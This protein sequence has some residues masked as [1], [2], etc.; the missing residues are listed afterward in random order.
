MRGAIAAYLGFAAYGLFW[1]TWGAALPALRDT[2]GVDGSELGIALL[3]VGA[4]ALPAMLS[5][6]RAVDRFGSR[7]GGALLIALALSGVII[8]TIAH[9]LLGLI[10]GMTLVGATSG[11]ADVAIN[12]QAGLVEQRSGRRVITIAHGVFSS[13]VVLGSAGAGALRSFGAGPETVF[14]TAGVALAIAGVVVFAV[15][16]RAAPRSVGH[17]RGT[18]AAP[19]WWV[20][21]VSVG[22]VGALG[23]AIENAHQSW[24]AIFVGDVLGA[25]P[26]VTAFAPA[27]FA[28]FAAATRF[29]VGALPRIPASV[30]LVGGAALATAGTLLVSVASTVPTAIAGLAVAAVGTAVLYPTLLSQATRD[31]P[32][33]QRGRATSAVTAMSYLGFILGPV[34]VGLLSTFA[35]MR[36]SM[37]G[38]A[39]LAVAFSVLAPLVIRRRARASVRR[40]DSSVAVPEGR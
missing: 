3:F 28:L 27:T 22:L 20:P 14:I 39:V 25:P 1:G 10:V 13:F 38:V 21:F 7:I 5:I 31:V 32:A 4:G 17:A 8:A 23:F 11:A 18:R 15:G 2:A 35:G 6:G 26:A 12:A 37:V 34:Y 29:A 24:S 30:L 19:L 40:P 36:G 16:D 33:D 9:D